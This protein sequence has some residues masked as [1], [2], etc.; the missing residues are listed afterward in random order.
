MSDLKIVGISV[1]Y[2]VAFFKNP[3]FIPRLNQEQT[4]GKALEMK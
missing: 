2:Q 3:E 1:I 4:V